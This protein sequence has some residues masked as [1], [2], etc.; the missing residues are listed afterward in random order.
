MTAADEEQRGSGPVRDQSMDS[1]V[2]DRLGAGTVFAVVVIAS[3]LLRL[4]YLYFLRQDILF[5]QPIMDAAVHDGWAR[6]DESIV[7]IFERGVPY[8]RAPL[9]IWFL[10]LVYSLNDS[11]LAPR[12]VQALLSAVTAGLVADLGRRLAGPIAGLLGGLLLAMAWPVIYF[13]GE[14][15]I[16]TFFMTLV[17]GALWLL[18][19]GSARDSRRWVMGGA[20]LLGLSALA[21]PTSLVLVPALILAPWLVWPQEGGERLRSWRRSRAAIWMIVLTLAPG[22]ALTLRNRVVGHDWVFIASQGGVNLF[23][24]NNPLADGRTAVVPGTR[25]TWLGG[26][27]DT[28]RRAEVDAGRPLR[29]SQVSRYYLR[30]SLES[31]RD[32]PRAMVRLYAKK[33]RYLVGAGE[34]PN[35]KNLHFWR[36]RNPMLRL[37]VWPSWATLFALGL[38]GILLIERRR[39]A[40]YVLAFLGLYALGLLPFFLNERFRLPLMISLGVFAGVPLARGLAALWQRRFRLAL[41]AFVPVALLFTLSELDRLDFRDDRIDAD[42]FSRYTL[43]NLYAER[44]ETDL[45]LRSYQEAFDIAHRFGLKNFDSVETM[46]RTNMVRLLIR[47][48]RLQEADQHLSILEDQG[49]P[50]PEVVLLRAQLRLRRH[51]YAEA[52]PLLKM[53]LDIAPDQPQALL[54]LGW[55]Q[56]ENHAFIAAQKTFRHQQEVAGVNAEALAGIGVTELLGNQNAVLARSF[57]DR[58]LAL[59]P[60]V[61]PAHQYLAEIYRKEGNIAKMTVHLREALRYDPL[62]DRVRRFYN[63][64]QLPQK[65]PAPSP[66][67]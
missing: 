39:R 61:A 38:G 43:G 16:V 45:A 47:K 5:A 10:K 12:F 54:G 7:A 64:L 11:Y 60:T 48:G 20:L 56:V 13:S 2:E 8:F 18:V 36:S 6:G 24:G 37:P 3:L 57:L 33:I 4:V 50:S 63:R 66:R 51:E 19:V 42:A 28:R 14:L 31:W 65:K 55:C 22:G 1:S 35:N 17:M 52:L 62:N 67:D 53:V 58:A 40:Y 59:D 23:I 21:R 34:R 15:L 29:P 41:V 46:L 32:A 44:G 49:P 9:Y 30:K 25:A 27:E 26:F